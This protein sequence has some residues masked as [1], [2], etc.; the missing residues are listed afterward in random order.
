M[1]QDRRERDLI[2][3]R[4]PPGEVSKQWLELVHDGLGQPVRLPV[5]LMR[6]AEPGPVC[7]IT[8]AVHGNEVNGIPAIHKLFEMIDPQKLRGTIAAVMVVNVPSMLMR[9]R[10][11]DDGTDLNHIFPGRATGRE[12]VVYAWRVFNRLIKHFDILLDLHTASFGRVNSLYVRADMMHLETRRMA[13]LQR[14]QII[15]HNPPSDGTL[16]GAAAAAGIPA[17]TVEIG[18]PSR[19]Q[20]ALINRTAK[21]LRAVLEAWDM[22]PHRPHL[23]IQGNPVICER[24]EWLYTQ[25]GGLLTVVPKVTDKVKCGEDV[26]RLVDPFGDLIHSYHAP[27]DGIVIGHSVDPVASTGARILHLGTIAADDSPLMHVK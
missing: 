22:V 19:F 12:S 3:E 18:N 17:V 7:G 13:L 16:R 9:R 8:A 5:M 21:G 26:A 6:G 20:T 14:P 11:T 10:R 27:H 24:S 1:N 2:L 4:F 23:R 15:V 25:H